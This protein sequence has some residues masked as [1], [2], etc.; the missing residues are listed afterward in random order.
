MTT[1][2]ELKTKKI[3]LCWSKVNAEGK[4]TK[5]PRSSNGS[6]SGTD[7][8]YSNTG[9]TFEEAAVAVKT[10][11]FDGVGFVVPEGY[12]FL[13]IDDRDL[14]DPFV[15]TL[16]ERFDSYSE[17]SF[18]GKGIHIYGTCD[19]SLLPTYIDTD[20]RR[21]LAQAYYT[22][23]SRNKLELYIGG[24]TNRYAAFTGNIIEDKP[25]RNCTTAVLTTLDQGMRRKVKVSDSR[26]ADCGLEAL[27]VIAS[28]RTQKNGEKFAKLFDEGDISEYDE[29]D[30]RVDAALCSQIA[31]RTGDDPELIDAVFRRSAL[32]RDKWENRE[33][34]REMT[35]RAALATCEGVFHHSVMPKPCFIS[36][37]SKQK[38]ESISCP[39]LARHIRE[40]LRY[41]FVS[42]S[43]GRG[44]RRLVYRDGCYR[45]QSEEML[46]GII[47]SYI[48]DYDE[49][50]LKM[51]DVNEV[52]L[53]LTTD[54]Q[55]V[56]QEELDADEDL[57]NF[58]NGLLR[59]SDLTLLPHSPDVYST[60]QI[61]CVW[62]GEEKP[63][64]NMISS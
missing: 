36:Y 59:L 63:T 9:V 35:I 13:D 28:L 31:F 20:G 2:Q 50:L 37:D 42:D 30:S 14:K 58:R 52:Y 12:F 10:H 44:V 24:I 7:E 17:Y 62:I 11:N 51:K 21:K 40:N 8:K 22:K 60:I 46:K 4:C 6:A 19:F 48:T 26:T 15:Q 57:I 18:S 56:R 64:R 47:K 29:D 43:R 39:L 16:M 32:C 34:Y 3:W 33:D 38:K 61:P 41:L 27:D 25:L 55:F 49:R 45:L 53:Q 5:V 1:I 54:L 23:N